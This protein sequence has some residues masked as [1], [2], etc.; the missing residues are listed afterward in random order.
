M[1]TPFYLE[2]RMRYFTYL[3]RTKVE[4][5]YKQIDPPLRN[6]I[7]LNLKIDL[8]FVEVQ[9]GQQPISE[10]HLKM[11]RVVLAKLDAD[12][13]VGDLDSESGFVAG[14]MP[15]RMTTWNDLVF[16]SGRYRDMIV[17][18]GG[19]LHSLAQRDAELPLVRGMG[20]TVVGMDKQLRAAFSDAKRPNE[21][22][23]GLFVDYVTRAAVLTSDAAQTMEFV[24]RQLMSA[25]TSI[26]AE[27]WRVHQDFEDLREVDP[28]PILIGSP[29]YVAE[30]I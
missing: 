7:A 9:A 17:C 6:R 15:L 25:E 13:A 29:L 1:G 30:K 28:V 19:S 10:N 5:L 11:L 16:L 21:G 22:S 12:G 23:T 14:K 8:P 24:A 3:S 4:L 20:S 26:Y 2:N 18:L 27:N